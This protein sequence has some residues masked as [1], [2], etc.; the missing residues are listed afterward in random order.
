M[1][2]KEKNGL[3]GFL[4]VPV[5]FNAKTLWYEQKNI[6][7][8]VGEEEGELRWDFKWDSR[9]SNYS[10]RNLIFENKGHTEA[11]IKVEIEG[12]VNNPSISIYKDDILTGS[13]ELPIE[14]QENEKI[15]YSTKDT[16]LYLVKESA[17]GMQ[18]NLFSVLDP[19]F[20][21][22]MKLNKGVNQ[23]KLTADDDITKA[24]ITIYVE[25]KAV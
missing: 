12:Y 4:A 18:T 21:N 3:N 14:I 23:I 7:L 13:L 16:D 8:T 9:F 2:I 22:F 11:P 5:T 24:K 25:Y 17:N 6:V 19:N 1:L 10:T 15:I 20:V